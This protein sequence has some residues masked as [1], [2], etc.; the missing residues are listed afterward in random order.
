MSQKRKIFL[1][2]IV[3]SFFSLISYAQSLRINE[4]MALNQSS[5]TDEDGEFS[6]WIEIYNASTAAVN[7]QNWKLTDD[8]TIPDKWVFPAVSI[9]SGSYLIVYASGKNRNIGGTQLHTNFK[10][11]GEGEYLALIDPSGNIISGF[12]PFPAQQADISYGFSDNSYINFADPTPGS[13]NSGSK[14]ALLPSPVF[15]MKHGFF[16]AAF[17]LTMSTNVGS[18]SIYYTTDGSFPSKEKGKLYSSPVKIDSTSVI[19]AITIKDGYTS[20]T[21]TTQTYLFPD[22]VIHQPNNPEGYPSIWG[23]YATLPDSAIAD[24]EMDPELM[25]NSTFANSVKVGLKD[26][27]TI[28]LVTDKDHFFSKKNDSVTGGIYIYTGPPSGADNDGRGWERPVSAEYFDSKDSVSFQIDCGI[29]LQGGHSRLPEK[30]PKHSFLLVFKSEYGP[31]KLNFPLFGNEA[32]STFDKLILRAGFGNSW[33][34]HSSSERIMA[35]YQRDIWGKDTQRAMGHPSSHSVYVH[36]YIN[37]IY[38]GIYAPSERMDKDFAESYLEGSTD[39]FDVIKDYSEIADGEI[40]AW[41]KMIEMAEAG[42]TENEDYQK[43][44]GKNPDG[45]INYQSEPMVDVENLSDYMLIN[46][47]GGNWDWDHHNWAAIRNRVEPGKGFKFFMWDAEHILEKT[48]ANELGENNYNCPSYVFQQLRQNNDFRLLFA[49]RAQKHLFNNGVLTTQPALARWNERRKQVEKS[50]VAESARW[51][52]YRRDVHPYQVAGPFAV[53]TYQDHWLPQQNYMT[54]TYFPNRPSIFINH[55]KSDDLFPNVASPSF[56][57]NGAI[58]TGKIVTPGDILTMTSTPGTIYYTTN[59]T[60]PKN[61]SALQYSSSITINESQHIKARSFYNGEWSA[62]NEKFFIVPDDFHDLKIT[63]VHYHPLNQDTID[64]SKFEFIEIK[65]TGKSTLDLDG[66][67]FAK[68]LDYEF[69]GETRIGPGEFIVLASSNRYFFKRYGFYAFDDYKGQLD[70]SGEK[71]ALVTADNDTI[72]SFFF[73]D[74]SGWPYASDGFGFSL[75]PVNINPDN[76]QNSSEYWRASYAIGGSPGADDLAEPL[77][78]DSP[79][80]NTND[81]SLS[82]N[83]PNPFNGSTYINYQIP[84]EA[85]VNISIYNLIGQHVS[86]LVNTSQEK[87]LYQVEWNGSDDTN[88]KVKPGIYYYKLEIKTATT[89]KSI[90]KKMVVM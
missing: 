47:Y 78:V 56:K 34:H 57:I 69:A 36:L 53:Y 74:D 13:D 79:S 70:N 5:I 66:L 40:T 60:D 29:R 12:N 68:G 88:N 45:T 90:T 6:D 85:L 83:Y 50:I 84:E 52:D 67:Y 89:E 15:S 35:Q 75:V 23:P 14:V 72:C 81:F 31:A 33:V 39:E 38:W 86:T 10:L 73:W 11:G 25:V 63:E 18:S 1:F 7:L 82:Q 61:T 21:I 19:R 30:N 77:T 17:N 62:L 4:F 71:I 9:P 44:Q 54:N 2:S 48:S 22:D 58:F 3:L 8:I 59:G 41:N 80:I 28:S 24:Y 76:N 46:F 64:D 37:G 20:S 51:G 65:N 87:G 43:I 26:I 42:L 16:E 27:P 32:D 55:L 49:D